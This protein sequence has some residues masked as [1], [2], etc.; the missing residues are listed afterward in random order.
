MT[1]SRKHGFWMAAIVLSFWAAVASAQM[2]TP[3]S[4]ADAQALAAPPAH[5]AMNEAR[6]QQS[7]SFD[8]QAL[9]GSEVTVQ[10]LVGIALARNPAIKSAVEH[11]EAQH[12]RVPQARALPDPTFSGGWM[13]HIVPFDVE[14]N[15]P[16]SF[17]GL[18]VQEQFPYPGKLKLRGEIADRQ[19]EAAGWAAE[20]TRRQVV[21]EVKA[22]YYS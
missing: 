13:G 6:R 22:A 12:A 8:D 21:S 2:N 11:S 5:T 17:R 14:H 9:A 3:A 20:L 7:G 10:E 1:G 18:T 4:G 16:P 15:F 19:A